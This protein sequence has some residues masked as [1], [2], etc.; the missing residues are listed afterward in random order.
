MPQAQ[1]SVP[2]VFDDSTEGI[3][4]ATGNNAAWMCRCGRKVPLLGRSG[5]S[6]AARVDCPECPRSY[7][8]VPEGG[9][10]TR[11]IK[12]QQVPRS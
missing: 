7:L 5:N 10:L 8:V 9:P 3:A 11:A 12:V 1:E 2:L 4:V 6:E